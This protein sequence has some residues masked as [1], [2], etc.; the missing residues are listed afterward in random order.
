MSK[1]PAAYSPEEEVANAVTHGLAAAAS[2]VAITLMLVKGMPTLSVGELIGVAIYGASLVLLFLA[3]TLYHSITHTRTKTVLKRLDHC[4]IYLLIAGTY[5]PL[6]M[7]TLDS[8]AATIML[9]LI[10]AIAISGVVFKLYFIHRFQRLSLV[11][12]LLMGWLSMFL[13]Y[14]LWQS[15]DRTGFWLLL[16]GGLCFT[17]GAGFYAAKQYRFT[18]AI[19]HVF[20]AAGAACHAVLIGVFVIPGS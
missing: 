16:A 4:A 2:I 14:D 13:I 5:T 11:T 3:S 17:L 9:W 18:H 10:W 19:W 8:F 20:V 1:A 7:I 15:L 12:Y 6:L